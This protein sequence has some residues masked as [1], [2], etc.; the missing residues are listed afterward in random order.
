M[1]AHVGVDSQSKLI[2]G[3]GAANTP[4]S[5][6]LEEWLHGGETRVWGSAYSDRK[7]A[8]SRCA[9][10]ARDDTR[11]KGAGH[12]K[13]SG[14][15]RRRNRNKSKA[16][17]KAEHVFFVMK[18]QFHFTKVRYKGSGQEHESYVHELCVNQFGRWPG[19]AY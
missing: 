19:S 7:K 4:D 1:K 16:R 10:K 18:R 11:K 6:V 5:E 12:R 13:L 3:S 8:L 15:E 14:E 17:R 2:L 9:P